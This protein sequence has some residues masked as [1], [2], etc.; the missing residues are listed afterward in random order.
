MQKV[1]E[2]ITIRNRTIK[3]RFVVSPMVT[4]YADEDGTPTERFIS[5]YEEKAKGG[6]GLIII[7]DLPIRP[8]VGAFR[9]LPAL[10]T[11]LL[12]Q[13]YKAFT[14]RL[15]H[16]GTV[17][18]AQIYHAG[19][20][21]VPREGI[22]AQAPSL[23]PTIANQKASHAMTLEE[24]EELIED[25]S[26]YALAAKRAGFDGVEVHG[27]HGYLLNQF[28]S[29][30]T[31]KR[32]DRYGGTLS[33]RNRLSCEI[34]K[35]IRQK[36]GDDFI[37]D[38]R[39]TTA[40]YETGGLTIEESKAM[41]LQ[42]EAAGI[43]MINV[44]QGSGKN[45]VVIPP[46]NVPKA[47]F[48]NNAAEIK[49]VVDIP[50]VATGR[51]NDPFLAEEIL[52]S[53]KADLCVMGRASIADP[54]MPEKAQQQKYDDILHCIG[55]NQ[56]CI[57]QNRRGHS[58]RCMVNPISGRESE[59]DLSPTLTPKTVFVAGGGVSGCE[60]A[61]AAASKGHNVVLYEASSQLGGQWIAASIP[62]DKEEFLSFAIWQHNKMQ[63]LGVTVLINTPLTSEIV[64]KH[65]PDAVIIA[66]GS[67]PIIPKIEGIDNANVVTTID[68][69]LGKVTVGQHVAVIGGGLAGAE[70]ALQL[71]VGGADVCIIELLPIIAKDGEPN[72]NHFLLQHLKD[73]NVRIYTSTKVTKIDQDTIIAEKGNERIKVKNIDTIVLA[74]GVRSNHA[75]ADELSDYSGLIV[76]TGDAAQAKNGYANIQ[77]SFEIGLNI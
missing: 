64:Q 27:A 47:N 50:V 69:L 22:S 46:S 35:R 1:F 61:I 16:Y 74:V 65:R 19:I 43:D 11:E 28:A 72:P 42:L 54:H 59:Y 55:C 20:K 12:I 45:W 75:L 17:V 5:Y 18:L 25:F 56:G 23:L 40:E 15:H 67:S 44:T 39:M 52:K 38:Y 60:A 63:E 3:N 36:V 66:T 9:H 2:P 58:V 51:I 31:N 70:T 68:V 30:L 49:K 14:D 76:T 53:G 24:I 4:N 13:Q 62:P 41:A 26:N 48:V 7:E 29:P 8:T 10:H 6:W 71:A 33:N 21:A 34:V 37:I 57:G 77:E 73:N 32:C